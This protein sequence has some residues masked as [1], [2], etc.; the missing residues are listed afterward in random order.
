M[1]PT[2][3]GIRSMWARV[4]RKSY[5]HRPHF[6]IKYSLAPIKNLHTQFSTKNSLNQIDFYSLESNRNHKNHTT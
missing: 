2:K 1:L 3:I 4:Y 6:H 5:T